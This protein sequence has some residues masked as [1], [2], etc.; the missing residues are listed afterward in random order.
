MCRQGCVVHKGS[1]NELVITQIPNVLF[2]QE[3]LCYQDGFCKHYADSLD[4][5]GLQQES[6]VRASFYNLI[7]KITDTYHKYHRI[8]MEKWVFESMEFVHKLGSFYFFLPQLKTFGLNCKKD[9]T[10][11]LHN[12]CIYS[13]TFNF[14]EVQFQR[15]NTYKP[16][17]SICWMQNGNP[18]TCPLFRKLTSQ[19]CIQESQKVRFPLKLN[20]LCNTLIGKA[21]KN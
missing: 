11:K 19:P 17:Y 2:F 13:Y 8:Q 10:K 16:V 7:R 5:C 6:V 9:N 20:Y 4:G 1:D 15:M 12:T 18:M 21:T 14:V 3:M